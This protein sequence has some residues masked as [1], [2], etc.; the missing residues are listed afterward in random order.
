[1]E[2]CRQPAPSRRPAHRQVS[3]FVPIPPGRASPA[4]SCTAR[5]EVDHPA[6]RGV[7]GRADTRGRADHD[8][9]EHGPPVPVGP[10]SAARRSRAAVACRPSYPSRTTTEQ[11]GSARQ[12][13]GEPSQPG[14]NHAADDHVD[15]ERA[16]GGRLDPFGGR[17]LG[18]LG[19]A[20]AAPGQLGATRRRSRTRC[21]SPSIDVSS[22][23]SVAGVHADRRRRGHGAVGVEAE[24]GPPGARRVGPAARGH[25]RRTARSAPGSR[26]RPRAS[27]R[28]RSAGTRRDE[29]AGGVGLGQAR[30]PHARFAAAP[31]AA[32]WLNWSVA[33]KNPL[34]VAVTS[35][36]ARGPRPVTPTRTGGTTSVVGSKSRGTRADRRDPGSS[37]MMTTSSQ[38]RPAAVQGPPR[39]VD[40]GQQPHVELGRVAGP[41]A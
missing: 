5:V 17:E 19:R 23:R 27:A 40:D 7:G 2:S 1:M 24:R 35:A 26:P 11:P 10:S 12:S 30:G 34:P 16:V 28:T 22:G 15:R 9:V 8:L 38:P 31:D 21:R 39:G 41:R 20:R 14:V 33:S 3:L 13:T 6:E 36:R 32:H 18:G 29:A 37:P 4:G 25:E